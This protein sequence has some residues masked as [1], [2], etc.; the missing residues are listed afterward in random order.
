MVLD[1]ALQIQKEDEIYKDIDGIDLHNEIISYK[2]LNPKYEKDADSPINV[3]N[4]ITKN[5]LISLFPNLCTAL[6]IFLCL[7]ISV[8]SEERSFSKLKNIKNI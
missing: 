4:Y 7:P 8:A 2:T 3:L 5:N 6:S 1:L